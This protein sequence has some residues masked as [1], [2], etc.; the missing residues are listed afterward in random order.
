MRVR[1]IKFENIPAMRDHLYDTKCEIDQNIN[2]AGGYCLIVE[3]E[4]LAE[5]TKSDT[6]VVIFLGIIMNCKSVICCRVTPS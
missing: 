6:S 3:G 5:I 2:Y 4:A 1:Y